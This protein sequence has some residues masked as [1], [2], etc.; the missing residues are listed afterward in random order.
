MNS[1]E[2][3]DQI[4]PHARPTYGPTLDDIVAEAA[5]NGWT[6]STL[7]A[8]VNRGIGPN[9]GTGYV[10]N[11]LKRLASSRRVNPTDASALVTGPCQQQCDHG[12]ITTSSSAVAPCPSCRPDT[13]RRLALRE[14]ARARGADR[15]EQTRLMTTGTIPTPHTYWTTR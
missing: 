1:H 3:L 5:G 10:I 8:E 12:W 11:T 9:T 6:T 2:L 14:E 13:A 15:D 7:A 4:R